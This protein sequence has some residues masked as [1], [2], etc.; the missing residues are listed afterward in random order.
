MAQDPDKLNE[1]EKTQETAEQDEVSKQLQE[2]A[3]NLEAG[4]PNKE[5]A[6]QKTREIREKH[7]GQMIDDYLSLSPN[8][9]VLFLTDTNPVN[10]DR[11]LIEAIQNQ[12]RA[13][14]VDF[15]ELAVS[16]KTKKKDFSTEVNKADLIWSSW[17]WEEQPKGVDFYDFTESLPDSGKRMAF[18]PGL[19]AEAL[20]EGGALTEQKDVLEHRMNRMLEQVKDAEVMRITTVYGTD[21]T[22]KLR[23]GDRRWVTDGGAIEKG[24]WD[25]LPKGEIYTTPDEEQANGILMLPVLQDE[26]TMDQGV[27]KFVRL[28]VVN[29]KIRGI[30]GGASAEKLR[31]YLQEHSLDESNP[32]S[33]LQIAE[34]AFGANSMARTGPSN[35]EGDYSEQVRPTVETEKRLGTMHM[36]FGSSQHG[37]DGADGHTESDVHLDFVIPR[38]GLTIESFNTEQDFRRNKNGRK[39]IDRGGWNF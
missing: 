23:K 24:I 29:G 30:S 2:M 18:C 31:T 28:E 7:A 10:T 36:A 32:E 8:E 19:T 13:R 33:V 9:R 5:Q 3:R 38:H 22:V 15:S 14:G 35:P 21:L 1:G 6:E 16:K 11:P 37:S 27:D 34:I 26:V 25:N 4:A 39:L 17:S 12:L 20:D